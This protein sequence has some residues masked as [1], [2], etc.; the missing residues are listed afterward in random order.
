MCR[1]GAPRGVHPLRKA[2]LGALW[3]YSRVH[4][5]P[6][7]TEPTVDSS[8]TADGHR[9]RG[10]H[11]DRG[12]RHWPPAIGHQSSS[13]LRAPS[14]PRTPRPQ[15]TPTTSTRARVHRRRRSPMPAVTTAHTRMRTLKPTPPSAPP[16]EHDPLALVSRPRAR[17]AP[18]QTARASAPRAR[19]PPRVRACLLATGAARATYL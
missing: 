9:R 11:N 13:S 8:P 3:P 17:R 15:T 14:A 6:R 18:A 10:W 2:Q 5:R 16:P 7:K 19:A 4:E 1:Y 12:R